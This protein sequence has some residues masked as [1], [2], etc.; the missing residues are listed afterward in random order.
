M[1]KLSGKFP[2]D[3]KDIG[4]RV[5]DGYRIF[6]I[7]LEER[8]LDDFEKSAR[9][10]KDAKKKFGIEINS[11][12]TPHSKNFDEYYEKTKEFAKVVGIKTIVLH[13]THIKKMYSEEILKKAVK[14]SVIENDTASGIKDIENAIKRGYKVCLDT[15]HFQIWCEKTGND[16]YKRL[17]ELFKN[18]SYGIRHI[19][20]NDAKNGKDNLAIGEGVID[21]ERTLKIISKYYS[22]VMVVEVAPEKQAEGKKIIESIIARIEN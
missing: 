5:K 12:H 16:F 8:H 9:I 15:A 21:N 13:S 14:N 20:Y 4:E 7:Y 17:E 1:I 19:H 3:M 11:V 22:G 2:P 18:Y 10:L 6:E